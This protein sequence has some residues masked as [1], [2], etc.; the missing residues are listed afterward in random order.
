MFNSLPIISPVIRCIRLTDAAIFCCPSQVIVLN[1]T[2]IATMQTTCCKTVVKEYPSISSSITTAGR[3]VLIIVAHGDNTIIAIKNLGN[4]K[5]N[6]LSLDKIHK[7][8]LIIP[9]FCF[10]RSPNISV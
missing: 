2:I 10:L 9:Y 7:L 4:V 5:S 8:L 6:S 1:K 3:Y